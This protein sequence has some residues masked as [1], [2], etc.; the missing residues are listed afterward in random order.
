MSASTP[1]ASAPTPENATPTAPTSLENLSAHGKA[2]DKVVLDY[3]R[4][5]GYTDATERLQRSLEDEGLNADGSTVSV[6]ELIK[7]LA[8]LLKPAP[9]T[10]DESKKDALPEL[11]SPPSVQALLA[12]IGPVGA[13]DILSTDPLDRQQ[14]YRELESWVDGSLDMYR[15]CLSVVPSVISVND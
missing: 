7:D 8:D 3:L 4:T 12:S 2:V 10:A 11:G 15:V 5:R 1:A 6:G 9:T 14:G 13:E